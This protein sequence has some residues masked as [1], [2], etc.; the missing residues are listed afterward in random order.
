MGTDDLPGA[1]SRH[2]G[3]GLKIGEAGPSSGSV[4]HEGAS[5]PLPENSEEVGGTTIALV[6][7]RSGLAAGLRGLRTTNRGA[8]SGAL[9]AQLVVERP[10]KPARDLDHFSDDLSLLVD[11]LRGVLWRRSRRRPHCGDGAARL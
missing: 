5:F 8:A 3:C 2:G 11:D 1:L 4:D 9:H 10:A 6:R 7:A